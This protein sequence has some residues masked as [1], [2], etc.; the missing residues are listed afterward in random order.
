MNKLIVPIAALVI[1]VILSGNLSVSFK[2]FKVSLQ[3][4]WSIL[5]A[6][7]IA[8]GVTMYAFKFYNDGFKKGYEIALKEIVE[9][10]KEYYKN[11]PS[12]K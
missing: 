3:S 5:A 9:F 10:N 8:T 6:V 12:N 4:P 2:P 1:I 11:N 7:L